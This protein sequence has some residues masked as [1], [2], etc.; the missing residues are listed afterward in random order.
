MDNL[1]GSPPYWHGWCC[2]DGAGTAAILVVAATHHIILDSCRVSV[3]PSNRVITVSVIISFW[4]FEWV[5][6]LVLLAMPMT[7]SSSE[8]ELLLLFEQL[9]LVVG[10]RDRDV[11]LDFWGFG[12][13]E[14]VVVVV[15]VVIG[16]V[17]VVVVIGFDELLVVV[18]VVVGVLSMN[19]FIASSPNCCRNNSIGS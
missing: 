1:L 3:D 7:P 13:D 11:F 10:R 6:V 2:I 5:T 8:P 17:V 15:V 19:P 12:F 14:L 9:L 18:V 16:V 4:P